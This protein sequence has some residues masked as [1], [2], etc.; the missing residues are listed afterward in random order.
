MI[1]VERFDGV[2]DEVNFAAAFGK[3]FGGGVDAVFGDD[4]EEVEV[5]V[6]VELV[7]DR[8]GVDVV[9]DVERLFFE[10]DLI[11]RRDVGWDGC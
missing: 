1:F 7:E 8:V 9:K 11:V 3:A 6:T 5:G 10:N 4:A 2:G